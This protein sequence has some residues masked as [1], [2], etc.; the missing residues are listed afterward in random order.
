ML[1][2]FISISIAWYETVSLNLLPSLLIILLWLN[3]QQICTLLSN[4]D[5]LGT[6]ETSIK[7]LAQL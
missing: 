5:Y 7:N 6:G 4:Y 2:L 3:N 1:I